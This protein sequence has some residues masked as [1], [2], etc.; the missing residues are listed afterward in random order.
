MIIDDLTLKAQSQYYQLQTARAKINTARI[1]VNSSKKS[2]K[3]TIIKNKAMLAPR[4]EVFEAETQLLRDK[5][6]LNNFY[7][8]EAEAIR[9]LSNTLG[10]NDNY[11]AIT[12]DQI[13]I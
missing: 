1:M 3:S 4:L 5:V 7:R 11:L 9:K 13:S 6:L 12:S 10:L 2:L 8:D